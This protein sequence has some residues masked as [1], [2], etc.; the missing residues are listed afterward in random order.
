MGGPTGKGPLRGDQWCIG[1]D[2]QEEAFSQGGSKWCCHCATGCLE[3][4]SWPLSVSS[5]AKP[6]CSCWPSHLMVAFLCNPSGE[7]CLGFVKKSV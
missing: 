3:I 1:M 6:K 7:C 4:A 5:K 2:S